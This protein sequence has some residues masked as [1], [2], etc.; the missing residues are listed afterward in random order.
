MAVYIDGVQVGIISGTDIFSTLMPLLM[1]VMV[2]M[3][4]VA[5]IKTITKPTKR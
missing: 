4:L 1:T 2:M 5:L 3:V